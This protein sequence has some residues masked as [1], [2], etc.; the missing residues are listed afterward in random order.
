MSEASS[1]WLIQVEAQEPPPPAGIHSPVRNSESQALFASARMSS[2]RSERAFPLQIAATQQL[3]S[4]R[5]FGFP[6][7]SFPLPS[8]WHL[9]DA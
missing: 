4:F 6:I 3:A 9:R 8:A 2:R 7:L 1:I 5:I